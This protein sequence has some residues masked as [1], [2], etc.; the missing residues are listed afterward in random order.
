M[1]LLPSGD[2]EA[3]VALALAGRFS[4][5]ARY[6]GYPGIAIEPDDVEL[7]SQRANLLSTLERND[8]ADAAY[9]EALRNSKHINTFSGTHWF[10]FFFFLI[11]MESASL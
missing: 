9:R 10:S 8:E 11:F 3:G 2:R 5:E 7:R 4:A 1:I 6:D